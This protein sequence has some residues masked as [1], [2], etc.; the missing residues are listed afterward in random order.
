MKKVK[1]SFKTLLEKRGYSKEAIKKLW[2]WYDYS[3]L[4]GVASF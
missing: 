4:K 1:P 3:E 2:T